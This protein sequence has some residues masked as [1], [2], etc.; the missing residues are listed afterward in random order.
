MAR[1]ALDES[2]APINA[3]AKLGTPAL[4][5]HND[6]KAWA[7]AYATS[8]LTPR[9]R[10]AWRQRLAHYEGCEF[11]ATI[12]TSS[13]QVAGQDVPE[14]FYDNI[15]NSD[16]EG[17]TQRERL[18]IETIERFAEDHES[19]RDDDDFWAR[20]HESFSETEIVDLCYHMIGPQLM[21]ALMAKAM[22]GFTEFCEVRPAPQN[23]VAAGPS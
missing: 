3:L 13:H 7:A 14:A 8:T 11:C 9:E 21:R 15:F 12:R 18:I 22:L 16:W 17:Y 19:L 5:A 23:A 20:M 10:E 2:I 4:A 6:T 1:V